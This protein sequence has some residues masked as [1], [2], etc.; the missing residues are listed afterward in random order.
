MVFRTLWTDASLVR[1]PYIWGFYKISFVI[2]IIIV[3]YFMQMSICLKGIVL[4]PSKIR[5]FLK[6]N[7]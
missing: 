6:F 7:C 3:D 4:K 2:T 1:K 5:W